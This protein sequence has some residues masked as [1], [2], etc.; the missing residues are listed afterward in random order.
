M[1][2][3]GLAFK[4]FG[5]SVQ[6]YRNTQPDLGDERPHLVGR[7]A[8][9]DRIEVAKSPQVGHKPSRVEDY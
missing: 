8:A 3:I 6:T 4:A 7:V 1:R 9:L 5:F 2:H